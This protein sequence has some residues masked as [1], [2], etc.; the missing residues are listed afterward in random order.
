MKK[1]TTIDNTNDNNDDVNKWEIEIY[2]ED[3]VNPYG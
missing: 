3:E 1:E 2:M